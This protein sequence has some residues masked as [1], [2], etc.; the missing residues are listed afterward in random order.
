MSKIRLIYKYFRH[1]LES[2]NTKG[3]GI[4][5]PYLYRFTQN[6]IYE[7][8]PFYVFQQIET[9]RDHLKN[10]DRWIEFK[11]FGTGFDRDVQVKTIAKKSLKRM[12]WAQLLFRIVNFTN[13]KNVLELGTSLGLTSAY[14]ASPSADIR[15]VTLEGSHSV[16]E[17]AKENF[18]KLALRNIAVEIGNIDA[19]LV[20]V[21]TKMGTLDV[22]FIDANHQK[23]SVLNYFEQ[24]IK[25]IHPETVFILDDIYWS[26][27]MED[28]WK[29][30]RKH[31]KVTATIDL[32][33]MGIV[34]FNKSFPKKTFKMVL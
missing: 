33:E 15:C 7:K 34:F 6:T 31:E 5:S 29:I 18:E 10:D 21:L 20:N 19:I 11:D 27:D 8:N 9:L 26:A 14:L 24:C 28:A 3:H 12:V 25:H 2:K 17:I 30:I 22:V 23:K 32:F 1:L 16:A 13:A 4:H